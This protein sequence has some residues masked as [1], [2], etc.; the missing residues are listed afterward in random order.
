VFIAMEFVSGT[1]VGY[2]LLAAQRGWAEVLRVFIEAGRGLA[3]AHDQHVVHHDFKP[4][5]VMIG[6]DGQVRVTDFG[7][8]RELRAGHGRETEELMLLGM[9]SVFPSQTCPP[10]P[11]EDW[12]LSVT[13][14]VARLGSGTPRRT[15]R[16]STWNAPAGTPAYMSPEQFL[17][18]RTDERTDQFSFCV[19]L[20]EALY[21]RRPFAGNSYL[22]LRGNV[23][24][25]EVTEEP[26]GS[27]VPRGLRRALLRGM[28]PEPDQRFESMHALLATLL[29]AARPVPQRS[30]RSGRVAVAVACAALAVAT[31]ILTR[32]IAFSPAVRQTGA[33]A[34][35]PAPGVT[36]G[37][38]RRAW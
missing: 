20:Y 38:A 2:W 36:S 11:G 27:D 26:P 10:S 16:T 13:R 32:T 6:Y 9:S 12:S 14:P 24:S 7:L 18:S 21:N 17:G 22:E 25:G 3:A 30:R 5:N 34:G 37:G 23:F 19:A 15:I 4:D 28:S 8:A 31:A 33:V 1:T 29:E 35:T